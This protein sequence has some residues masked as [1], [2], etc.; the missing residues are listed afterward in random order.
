[1]GTPLEGY[2][3]ASALCKV[4]SRS[5]P[6]LVRKAAPV[7]TTV[8]HG[9]DSVEIVQGHHDGKVANPKRKFPNELGHSVGKQRYELIGIRKGVDVCDDHMDDVI[10]TLLDVGQLDQCKC[11]YW[12]TYKKDE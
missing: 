10:Y 1:M 7:V 9:G 6:R 4:A 8:R 2:K 3:M 5:L 12:W 11:G